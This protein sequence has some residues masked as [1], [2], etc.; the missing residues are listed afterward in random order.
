MHLEYENG[1]LRVE[2]AEGLRWQI[3]D[4]EKPRFTFEYDALSVT[5]ARA[6]RRV[7]P[8]V[9]PLNE[10]ELRQV[11][12]FVDQLRPPPWASLQKQ[13]ATDLR[14]LARG[15][16]NSV[17]TQLEYDG[18]LDVM[19]TGREGSTDLYAEEAR[20]VLTYVDSVWNAYHGLAEQIKNTPKAELKTVKE[21]ADMMPFPPTIEHFSGAVFP[22]LFNGA[23]GK[24]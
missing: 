7:G 5:D 23:L 1:T 2:N 4:V 11:R 12:A 13:I 15:L 24:R 9:Q 17:V 19:I 8:G 6:L 16:I 22:E 20:R 18:L 14:A 3:T 21:Y 10:G